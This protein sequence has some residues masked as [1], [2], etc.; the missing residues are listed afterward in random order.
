VLELETSVVVAWAHLQSPS[1][2]VV[3]LVSSLAMVLS[4]PAVVVVHQSVSVLL[5]RKVR[6]YI[7]TKK[8]SH[9]VFFWSFSGVLHPSSF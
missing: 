6:P 1:S 9:I 2:V 5:A 3:L 4:T 7:I 8:N